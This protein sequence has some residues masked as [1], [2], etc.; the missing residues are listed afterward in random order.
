MQ[1]MLEM[2][3]MG[4]KE[5]AAVDVHALTD[6][7][8][9]DAVIEVTRLRAALEAAESRLDFAWEQRGAW[10]ADGAR[11]AAAWMTKTTQTPKADCGRRLW[12][13]RAASHMALAA[14][15]WLAGEIDGAHVRRLARA[16]N[17]RTEMAFAD[18]E[19]F[20]VGEAKKLTYAEF[21]IVVS[22]WEAHADPDGADDAAME[23]RSRRRVSL[24]QTFAGM[25]SGHMLLDPVSGAV[26]AAELARLEQAFFEADWAEARE[27]LGRDP[28]AHELERTPDQR[29][30]DALVEMA[31]RS[32]GA[33]GARS[34]GFTHLC[35]LSTG[36]VV[37]PVDLL[38]WLEDLE[39]EAILFDELGDRAI[40]ASRR[41]LFVGALRRIIEVRDQQ[42]YHPMCEEPLDR[43]QV[44]HIEPWP[45][46]GMTSQDN[47]R[48]AC[49]FHNRL[50]NGRPPPGRPDDDED[51]AEENEDN[52]D[53]DGDADAA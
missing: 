38:P 22:Y 52:E 40:R 26:V 36:K 27:R 43:C 23:Q 51:G 11:S 24:D 31:M 25:W 30:A 10:R 4:V 15:A 46:G 47:G 29:R 7:E 1:S 32:R 33:T 35:Q 49:G 41:R 8:L 6:D 16:R 20:L 50:R 37:R 48:L 9:T 44:D 5:A 12:A 21:D 42:C 13:G 45:L 39:L 19:A 2:L 14:E 3:A 34:E 53:N 18:A 17:R 28:A